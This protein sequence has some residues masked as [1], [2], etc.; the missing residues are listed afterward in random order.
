MRVM[1]VS[2]QSDDADRWIQRTYESLMLD[3]CFN[4]NYTRSC[5]FPTKL[6]K[7]CG[8]GLAEPC[9][10]GGRHNCM[11]KTGPK[12][13]TWKQILSGALTGDR[14]M[15]GGGGGDEKAVRWG[16]SQPTSHIQIH[17]P[18]QFCGL[19]PKLL[20][21][22]G[23]GWGGHG[24]DVTLWVY[25]SYTPVN[26]IV[27]QGENY[28]PV[29]AYPPGTGSLEANT[30]H[31]RSLWTWFPSQ[32]SQWQEYQPRPVNNPRNVFSGATETEIRSFESEDRDLH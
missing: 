9:L 1:L 10:L 32:Q 4:P 15:G 28:Q 3:I 14:C 27:F 26:G 12:F 29:Y 16:G 25:Y 21:A 5:G 20:L 30:C 11:G 13:G 8:R 17:H 23:K 2:G 31:V 19:P 7:V 24:S 6:L 22:L 18:L